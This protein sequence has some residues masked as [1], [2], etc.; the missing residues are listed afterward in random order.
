MK[1]S[2]VSK[3]VKKNSKTLNLQDSGQDEKREVT[4]DILL[5]ADDHKILR[6]F[7]LKLLLD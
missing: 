1:P 5:C 6:K 4:S 7:E 2:A 3:L